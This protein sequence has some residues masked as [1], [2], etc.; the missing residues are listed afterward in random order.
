MQWDEVEREM[1][2]MASDLRRLAKTFGSMA[3]AL[4][5]ERKFA[6]LE[7]SEGDDTGEKIKKEG[8]QALP[9]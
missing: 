2:I 3:T 7:A 6:K 1:Y 4:Q 9:F 8:Q 5:R